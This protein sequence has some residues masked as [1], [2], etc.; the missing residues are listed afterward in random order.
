MIATNVNVDGF[1]V[2][3]LI[4]D[5]NKKDWNGNLVKADGVYILRNST[6]P[7]IWY[8]GKKV[9]TFDDG[10]GNYRIYKDSK[11]NHIW[12]K[13]QF[14]LPNEDVYIRLIDDK[15][16]CIMHYNILSSE[17]DSSYNTVVL[18]CEL[19]MIGLT[20]KAIAESPVHKIKFREF[21]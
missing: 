18:T 7:Y 1:I 17:L 4:S 10:L 2:D 9:A 19:E 13:A 11:A 3:V 12:C 21:L 14:Y 5:G 15:L 6:V 8:D 16:D 20:D